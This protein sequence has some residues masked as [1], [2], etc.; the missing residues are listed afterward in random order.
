MVNYYSNGDENGQEK[1]PLFT[2]KLVI[3][4]DLLD[5]RF[6]FEGK[7][8]FEFD[9]YGN[10]INWISEDV[11]VTDDMGKVI[12]IQPNVKRPDF[13][14]S[15]AI[16]VV[17]SKYF[18]GNQEKGEREDS[19]EKLIGR[20][21]RYFAR[22]A[23]KQGYFDQTQADILK[24]ELDAICVNQMASFNSP[25]W[26]NCGIQGYDKDA[27]GVAPYE[28]DLVLNKVIHSTKA[29]DRPQCSACFIQS[30]DDNMESIMALQVS[31]A[32]LFKA[33]SGTGTNRSSLRSSK[34][35]LTGARSATFWLWSAC[36]SKCLF[37]TLCT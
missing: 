35:R 22:Q 7:S 31:E 19:V 12:F 26:F 20:V 14:S 37:S 16:K 2:P 28:W 23:V 15:L 13:W 18:W 25:V 11:R 27:G 34:E 3:A 17:A 32:M 33:G 1:K 21:S 9:I 8:P 24:S 29:E 5:R 4:S 30:V 6:S 36:F 10:P